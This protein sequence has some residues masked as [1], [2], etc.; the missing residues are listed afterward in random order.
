MYD[1]YFECIGFWASVIIINTKVSVACVYS[2]FNRTAR[3]PFFKP[4]TTLSRIYYII[5]VIFIRVRKINQPSLFGKII[6]ARG[7]CPN[8]N[9]DFFHS[10]AISTQMCNSDDLIVPGVLL[11]N[12]KLTSCIRDIRRRFI[13]IFYHT[14]KKHRD[15]RS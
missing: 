6:V 5:R 11:V 14:E 1:D 15:C 10:N 8:N 9:F 3:S 4:N 12:D 2:E 7:I 13:N